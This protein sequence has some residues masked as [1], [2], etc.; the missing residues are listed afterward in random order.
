MTWIIDNKRKRASPK[1]KGACGGGAGGG[2]AASKRQKKAVSFAG[3]ETKVS[4]EEFVSGECAGHVAAQRSQADVLS[5]RLGELRE[6]LPTLTARHQHRLRLET[7][8]GIAAL[9]TQL[10][11]LDLS[12]AKFRA[13]LEPIAKKIA[14]VESSAHATHPKPT[15]SIIKKHARNTTESAGAG[16][17]GAATL[18][19]EES[20]KVVKIVSH[21]DREKEVGMQ[22]KEAVRALREPEAPSALVT[23]YMS[24]CDVCP[25]C[26]V[27]LLIMGS[28]AIMGCPSCKRSVTF[29]QATSS[30]I[31]YGQE[32]EFASF[33]YRKEAHFQEWLNCFQFKESTRVP[34][35]VLALVM[36]VH[37]TRATAT[38]ASAASATTAADITVVSVREAM[39]TMA[40]GVSEEVVAGTARTMRALGTY[41]GEKSERVFDMVRA[42]GMNKYYDNKQQICTRISG[43]PAPN[44]SPHQEEQ[45]RCMFSAIIPLYLKHKPPERKNF[46][47]Y[48]VCLYKFCQLMG[49]HSFLKSFTLLKGLAKLL[50]QIQIFD[51]ISKDLDWEIIDTFAPVP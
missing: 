8:E 19:A 41:A 6:K 31:A 1:K 37:A 30:R 51:L 49:W 40:N 23:M 5:Q 25:S 17:A 35:E 12:G 18:E 34:E 32:V 39:R 44:M 4:V 21:V 10:E 20:G 50:V 33:T 28:A 42:E 26:N 22:L 48:S 13:A 7:A 16:G 45:A 2:G 3:A 24:K 38:A 9:E 47:S 46:L 14:T 43:K 36:Y 29:I 11:G 27:P 15:L